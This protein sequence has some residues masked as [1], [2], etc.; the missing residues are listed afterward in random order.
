LLKAV[1]VFR[2]PVSAT[3]TTTEKTAGDEEEPPV[4][5]MGKVEQ[6]LAS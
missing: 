1:Q 6:K 2:L 5:N 4:V 3:E